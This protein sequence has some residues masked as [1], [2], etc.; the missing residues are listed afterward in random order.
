MMYIIVTE[1]NMI[2]AYI[3]MFWTVVEWVFAI[4]ER[5]CLSATQIN[6]SLMVCAIQGMPQPIQALRYT[7]GVVIF[8]EDIL[9]V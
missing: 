7:Q 5:K 8:K 2:A 3:T 6:D 4:S 9:L 1:G